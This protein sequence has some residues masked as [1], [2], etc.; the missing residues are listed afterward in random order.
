MAQ[1]IDDAYLQALE[2]LLEARGR[3][4]VLGMGKSGLIGQN[5]VS[6]LASTGTP[7]VF[8]HPA[9]A[10]HGDL[11]MIQPGDVAVLI[12]YSGETE[13]VI[14]L[15]PFLRSRDIS[16]VAI[17]G[18]LK[19]TLARAADAALDI[20]V[21]REVC[22]NN[23]APTA[24]T[25]TT[26]AMANSLAVSLMNARQFSAS[27]FAALHPGGSLGRRL[28]TRV[29]DAM[30]KSPV[31]VVEPHRTVQESLFTISQGRLGL[32]LI[33]DGEELQGIVTDGDLRRALESHDDLR[34]VKI[35]DIMTRNPITIPETA[36]LCDAEKIMKHRKVTAL[37]V[38][39]EDQHV[40]GIVGLFDGYSSVF[41]HPTPAANRPGMSRN[42]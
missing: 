41:A 42:H 6:T 27:D 32:V 17:V 1:R 30:R 36:R 28:L 18:E 10:R 38:L 13:E 5:M 20:S 23:L 9:E 39:D 8:V 31:P 37:V 12:S 34:C 26:L 24:S 2:L 25:A 21:E 33:M 11:G 3:V 22:P 16:I 40:A 19:S 15:I 29:K 35:G 14:Q 4:A 7:A